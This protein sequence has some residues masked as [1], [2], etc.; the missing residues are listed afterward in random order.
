MKLHNFSVINIQQLKCFQN[1]IWKCYC[2]W[3]QERSRRRWAAGLRLQQFQNARWKHC[4]FQR[5]EGGRIWWYTGLLSG[6]SCCTTNQA[7]R[8]GLLEV[9]RIS[10]PWRFCRLVVVVC[11]C[12]GWCCS[13]SSN[14]RWLHDE[15]CLSSFSS[16]LL[17][18]YMISTD[19]LVWTEI[20]Q[21]WNTKWEKNKN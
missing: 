9:P 21:N 10:F 5:Q 2:C 18:F 4:C 17:H 1:M 8:F 12:H 6:R 20:P 14:D 11:P 7:S 3:R 16:S 13:R 19:K 15:C